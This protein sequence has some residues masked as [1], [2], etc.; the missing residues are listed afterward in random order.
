MAGSISNEFLNSA[1]KDDARAPG[2]AIAYALMALAQSIDKLRQIDAGD[3]VLPGPL[4]NIA[5]A[6]ESLGLSHSDVPGPLEK[7]AMEL[8]RLADRTK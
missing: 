8:E 1:L 3:S 4:E 2:F 7:I 6:I 5:T